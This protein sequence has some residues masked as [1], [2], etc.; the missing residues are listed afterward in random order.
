M[1]FVYSEN[2]KSS[3]ALPLAYFFKLMLLLNIL[4]GSRIKPL[5]RH[6]R[7]V[8]VAIVQY[9]AAEKEYISS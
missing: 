4:L 8:E 3:Q 2:R 1:R 6:Y 9:V 7:Y 5:H